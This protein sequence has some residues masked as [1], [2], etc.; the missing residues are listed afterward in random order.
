[1]LGVIQIAQGPTMPQTLEPGILNLV[2]YPTYPTNT[3][4]TNGIVL[5]KDV[6]INFHIIHSFSLCYEI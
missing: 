6:V 4:P 5:R 3:Y 1:M 2:T